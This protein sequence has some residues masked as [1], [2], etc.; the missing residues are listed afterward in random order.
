MAA[1]SA[2]GN[3]MEEENGVALRDDFNPSVLMEF[4]IIVSHETWYEFPTQAVYYC[5]AN[6]DP[7]S[8][9]LRREEGADVTSI[10]FLLSFVLSHLGLR[11]RSC[12]RKTR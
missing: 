6:V 4:L 5:S 9:R 2:I 1:E 3:G 8:K 11:I 10:Y 7:T 12:R